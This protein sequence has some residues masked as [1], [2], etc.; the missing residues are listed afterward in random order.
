[1]K[2][3]SITDHVP[4]IK[5]YMKF[6]LSMLS[7]ALFTGAN[8]QTVQYTIAGNISGLNHDSVKLSIYLHQKIAKEEVTI[9]KNGTF[10]FK[11]KLPEP[12]WLSYINLMGKGRPISIPLFI[13]PG[14]ISVRGDMNSP[15][16][17]VVSGTPGNDDMR[18]LNKKEEEVRAG[19][20]KL[21]KAWQDA[22]ANNNTAE[23]ERIKKQM[24]DT[25]D[26]TR[27]LLTEARTQF[28]REHPNSP[29]SA[30]ALYL[31][32]DD[33][34]WS[35]LEELYN[36]LDKK[37]HN[38][39]YY[40]PMLENKIAAGKRVDIGQPAPEFSAA[41]SSGKMISLKDFRG[42]Y[43]LLDFWASWCVPC[44]E[45]MKNVKKMYEKYK[46][47]NFVVLGFSLDEHKD[48]WIKALIEDQLAWPNTSDLK[49]F[50]SP[51]TA[52]WGVQPIPDNFLIG[53]DGKILGRRLFGDELD[54]TL[55]EELVLGP[56]EKYPDSLPIV[57]NY[58]ALS[59]LPADSLAPQFDE[60]IKKNPRSY[61]LPYA[62][63]EKYFKER[64][65][66][67]SEYL[68]KAYVA[69]IDK[70][71]PELGKMFSIASDGKWYLDITRT[72]NTID[73]LVK[74]IESQPDSLIPQEQ[75]VFLQG[76]DNDTITRKFNEWIKKYPRSTSFPFT[77]GQA[78]YDKESP[79]A[80]PYL[81]KVVKI[82]PTNAKV[83]EMLSIDAERWGDKK[84]A[85][86]YMGKAAAAK[87]DEPSY[88]FYH[89]MDYEDIDPA[90]WK[91]MLYDLAKKFPDSERGAQGLYWLGARTEP[92]KEKIKIFEQLQQLYPPKKFNWSSGGMS[93]L[94]DAYISDNQPA[95]AKTLAES[96]G[97]EDNWPSKVALADN[98]IKVDQLID[99]K[100]YHDAYEV[101]DKIRAPRYS[102]IVN[103]IALMKAM[104]THAAG[105]TAGA[106]DSLLVLQAK[107]PDPEIWS[108]I[109][110]YGAK[111]GKS[112]ADAGKDLW[113]KREPAIK[114]APDFN[115]GL[116]TSKD[117]VSLKSLRGQVVLLTFWFPGCGPCRG[118]FPHFENVIRKFKNQPVSFYGINVLPEQDEYVVPF[119]KGTKYSFI[120]LRGN[121]EWALK[122]YKVRGEPTNFLIDQQ[123]RIVFSNFMI[124]GGNEKML[125]MMIREMLGHNQS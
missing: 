97:E 7:L 5:K 36:L 74:V 89:A 121:S 18:L 41:D 96:M 19:S 16:N 9:A 54:K 29:A 17:I 26:S 80:K 57:R 112:T 32:Q 55:N 50:M 119:M 20:R 111:L 98:M 100:K 46:D 110:D 65:P 15:D 95:K 37:F 24:D 23:E 53:P 84:A 92:V 4:L 122:T 116:Y 106:Y 59:G 63:G 33:L 11:G 115:L 34:H 87:P 71:S 42:K 118:E 88:A 61:A 114:P 8:A 72:S 107:T 56:I 83:W 38:D 102:D 73:S 51:V 78:W 93:G 101:I 64:S 14:L 25:Y 68:Y 1:M 109:K 125:E 117:S 12:G 40:G 22:K 76:V 58:I 39:N 69:T 3:S 21:Q 49:F 103:K 47:K 108:A 62:I 44:R 28:V 123:G 2:I 113:A 45:E 77:V 105:N 66:K 60:W 79:K 30:T 6:I 99:E 85:R 90:K 31:A 27:K 120:P 124:N 94:F 52:L 81:L 86:E 75:L 82:D 13:E 48:R 43:V 10:R 67:A 104:V 91:S 70:P 35:E